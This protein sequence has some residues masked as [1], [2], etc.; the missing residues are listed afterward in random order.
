MVLVILEVLDSIVNTM[1][2][3]LAGRSGAR[4]PAEANTR[5]LSETPKPILGPTQPRIQWVPVLFLR[6]KAAGAWR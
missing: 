3:L 5:L 6:G 1:T 4:I 2:R